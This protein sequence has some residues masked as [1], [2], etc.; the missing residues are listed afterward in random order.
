MQ[1][2]AVWP[3]ER[4]R[5]RLHLVPSE[6]GQTGLN[7]PPSRVCP[8]NALCLAVSFK[9]GQRTYLVGRFV[10][11]CRSLLLLALSG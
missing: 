6:S 9:P 4:Q 7:I 3:R 2:Q 5:K 11:L 1:E 10:V 8:M